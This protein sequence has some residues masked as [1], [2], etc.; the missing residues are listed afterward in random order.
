MTKKSIAIV[1]SVCKHC[2]QIIE[3]ANDESSEDGY[4]DFLK[5]GGHIG[6]D[7][8]TSVKKV[9]IKN[10]FLPGYIV[11]LDTRVVPH[12]EQAKRARPN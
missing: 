3:I 11:E 8:I 9:S 6:A 10:S 5:V 1:V 2:Q 7:I 12:C 4:W